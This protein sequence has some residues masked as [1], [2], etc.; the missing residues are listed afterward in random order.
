M[1]EVRGGEALTPVMQ[2][3]VSEYRLEVRNTRLLRDGEM[4]KDR[5]LLRNMVK[6]WK[7]IK[8][9]RELQRFSN[10]PYK[11]CLRK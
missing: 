4:E 1:L 9:L 3:R 7:E 6:L 8:A 11:L 5:T 10:T 2:R